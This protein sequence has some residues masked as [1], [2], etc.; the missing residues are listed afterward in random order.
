MSTQKRDWSGW[1]VNILLIVG[2]VYV[3]AAMVGCDRVEAPASQV[4][5]RFL[6]CS[7]GCDGSEC[8]CDVPACGCVKCLE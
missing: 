8:D 2:F 5:G 6:D 1:Y 3:A 7:C 4:H